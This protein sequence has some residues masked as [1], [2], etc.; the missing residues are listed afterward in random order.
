MKS[1]QIGSFFWSVFSLFGPGKTPYL[2][3]FHAVEDIL[4][5]SDEIF[6]SKKRAII[7]QNNHFIEKLY[8]NNIWFAN[9]LL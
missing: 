8:F 3:T 4:R 2:N 1:V 9:D 7:V 5:L 6:S